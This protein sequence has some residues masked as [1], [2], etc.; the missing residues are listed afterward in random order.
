VSTENN[1]Q[2]VKDFFAAIGRGDQERLLVL[3]DEEIEGILPGAGWPLAGSYRGH[4]GVANLVKMA[5]E[6]I[7]MSLSEPREFVAQETVSGSSASLDRKR[8]VRAQSSRFFR[9]PF[10]I[11]MQGAECLVSQRSHLL[12]QSS[13]AGISSR[14]T[15]AVKAI[16]LLSSET[17]V[18][19]R[20]GF[21]SNFQPR[22]LRAIP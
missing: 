21:R 18:G 22:N 14:T 13:R 1:V 16:E 15:D 9:D 11:V 6:T 7:E 2:T 12:P 5:S 10:E 4:V 8:T 19:S 17:F 3:V 20:S